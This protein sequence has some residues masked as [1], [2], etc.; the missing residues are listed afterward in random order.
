[1]ASNQLILL[2]QALLSIWTCIWTFGQ[3]YVQIPPHTGFDA[4]AA[5]YR[6]Q[7]HTVANPHDFDREHNVLPQEAI[8]GGSN[9]MLRRQV[10]LRDCAFI[11]NEAQLVVALPSWK[12]SRGARAEIFLAE[13]CG[14][15]VK[16]LRSKKPR[17]RQEGALALQCR[18]GNE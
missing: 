9:P 2:P 5:E 15:P 18:P 3:G 7:G 14:I 4:I 13:A 17:K 1:M 6:A 8:F 12:R 11:C 16:F 10:P